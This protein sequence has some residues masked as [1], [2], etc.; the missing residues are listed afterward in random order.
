MRVREIIEEGV[1]HKNEIRNLQ[2]VDTP[3]VEVV[4]P[5]IVVYVAENNKGMLYL[6]YTIEGEWS[7]YWRL[8]DETS[9]SIIM[10]IMV[11]CQR[12]GGLNRTLG[13]DIRW[14]ANKDMLTPVITYD[15]K[16]FS[17]NV[18][19]MGLATKKLLDFYRS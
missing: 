10:D 5:D 8:D 7:D 17:F 3:E 9:R 19:A 1:P 6:G 15:G 2:V 14:T 13:K 11:S 16:T 4:P 12:I 18:S